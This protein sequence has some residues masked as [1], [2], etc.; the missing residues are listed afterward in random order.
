MRALQFSTYGGPEVLQWAE[1]P[2]PHA[3]PGQIR[4]AV[5]AASVNPIDWKLLGAL[6]A[7]AG[8]G[9]LGNLTVTNWVRDKGFG[10]GAKVGAIPSAVGGQQIQLSHVGMVFPGSD[11][12]IEHFEG[13]GLATTPA[14]QLRS[15]RRQAPEFK[16]WF[17]K[18]GRVDFFA[19]RRQAY[20]SPRVHA[21]LGREGR[22]HS[23][24]RPGTGVPI[25][26]SDRPDDGRRV[27]GERARVGRP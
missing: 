21:E 6:A 8:S 7:T 16:E 10:M 14:D 11:V 27:A 18:T 9:G 5:R 20:G 24:R 26:R 19:A 17:R 4:I 23:R 22:R 13:P 15:I 12:T 3:G 25:I 2:E 1:A